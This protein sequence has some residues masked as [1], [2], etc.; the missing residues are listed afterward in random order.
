MRKCMSICFIVGL[1]LVGGCS[2]TNKD[3]TSKDAE[4]NGKTTLKLIIKDEVS[5]SVL[6]D[7]EVSVE[8]DVNTLAE[9]L[10]NAEELEVEMEDGQYGKTIL[11]IKGLKTED[12]NAG[13][14]W[15]YES[16][17]NESCVAMGMCDAADALKIKDGDSFTFKYTTSFN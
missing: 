1:L 9:F 16:E 4:A 7:D 6:L 15:L 8:K 11:G 2:S 14:W 5:G 10:E 3:A 12:F 17:T 13:P